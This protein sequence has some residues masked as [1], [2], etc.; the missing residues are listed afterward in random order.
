[1]F[2]RIL[3]IAS[4]SAL[5]AGC[6]LSGRSALPTPY[7]ADYLPTAIHLTAQSIEASTAS[8]MPPAQS[9]TATA[10]FLPA[11]L[12]PSPTPTPGLGIPLAAIQI[13]APGPM[14]RIVS[15]I[16][17]QM[18]AIAANTQK[19]EVDLFGE[20]GRLLGRSLQAVAGSPDGDP[21][22]L[23][24]PFEVRGNED[25]YLQVSTRDLLGIVQS[26]ITV[27]VLLLPIGTSQINPAGNTIY[28]RVAFS[29]L[30]PESVATGGVLLV[31]GQ[32]LPYNRQPVILELIT[33][34]GKSLSTRV[35]S[36]SGTD[37]QHFSTTLP[38]K[39]DK[40]TPARLFVHQADSVLTGQAYVYSQPI[41]LNR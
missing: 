32:I 22:S 5:L 25:G 30:P 37:W 14:S 31:E 16:Q 13:R 19:I 34:D 33:D 15:P 4:V 8:A 17:V 23:K 12:A 18:L 11:T 7:P 28:E 35:L 2:R 24:M 1:M 27:Q 38:F 26:L 39:V 20:D 40:S 10:T 3:V 21:L 29:D 41:L 9:P 6:A 36:A